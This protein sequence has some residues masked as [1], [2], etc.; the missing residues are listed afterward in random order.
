VAEHD[1]AGV[2]L[3]ITDDPSRQYRALIFVN[4]WQMGQY[5]NY[6]GP[7]HSFPIPNGVL[8]PNGDNTIAI[9]VW[10]L[11]GTTGGLEQVSLT[12]YGSHAS[13]LTVRQN[14]SPGYDPHKY[15]VR[16]AVHPP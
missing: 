15:A 5:I 2:G 11:D 7:E 16:P 14:Y 3:T 13:P 8:N 4:G 6:L 9:A 1:A 12:N 10:N